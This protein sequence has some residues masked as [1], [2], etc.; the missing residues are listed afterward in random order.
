MGEAKS[1]ESEAKSK[2]SKSRRLDDG[3]CHTFAAFGL[4][5]FQRGRRYERGRRGRRRG[6]ER[7]GRQEKK[8][9][10]E[11]QEAMKHS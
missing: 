3:G 11:V 5:A 4:K 7:G 9:S 1:D 10:E 2:I 6:G 8:A